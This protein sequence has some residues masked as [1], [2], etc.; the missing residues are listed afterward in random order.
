M[1]PL[2]VIGAAKYQSAIE[3]VKARRIKAN[4][5]ELLFVVSFARFLRSSF[6]TVGRDNV[7]S[8]PSH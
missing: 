4:Q 5:F 8:K 2:S 1:E 6:I 7:S 3:V